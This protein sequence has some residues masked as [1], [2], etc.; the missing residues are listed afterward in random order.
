MRRTFLIFLGI[1]L[2]S[3]ASAFAWGNICEDAKDTPYLTK[4]Q[5]DEFFKDS[6]RGNSYSGTGRV[7]DVRP[8]GNE[9]YVVV[10][11]GNDVIVNV[12]TSSSSVKDLK[13]GQEVSFSGRCAH[14]FRRVYRNT[15]NVYQLFELARGDITP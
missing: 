6:L 1:F 5:M 2:F 9:Y 14:T 7:R 4:V 8:Y 3:A 15:K 10:D 12:I 11:C 13:V